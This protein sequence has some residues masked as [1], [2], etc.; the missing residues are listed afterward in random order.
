VLEDEIGI[1]K[2][3]ALR[4]TSLEIRE[5]LLAHEFATEAERKRLEAKRR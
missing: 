5:L 4:M 2:K 3:D 1:P